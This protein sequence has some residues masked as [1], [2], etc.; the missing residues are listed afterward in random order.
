MI[1]VIT[2]DIINSRKSLHGGNWIK[3]LETVL[4]QY[5]NRFDRWDI[6]R[7]DSFQLEL[8]CPQYALLAAIHIK[9]KVKTVKGL[10]VRMAIGLGEKT[11]E[12]NRISESNGPAFIYSGELFE[13]LKSMKRNAAIKSPWPALDAEL[14]LML[15][16]ASIAMDRWSPSSA[17]I[18]L[19]SLLHQSL[20]QQ[21]LGEKI[22]IR[23]S[24]VSERQSRAYY[25]EIM[26]LERYYR[27][28]FSQ[29][30]HSS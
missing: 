16:L 28:R 11:Y 22:G 30:N 5:G 23:Q 4:S 6:F 18:V 15:G 8:I 3:P 27:T 14:N 10:D 12:A 25:S 20:S 7:G 17:E 1:A 21:E 19:M 2:G 29:Q 26:E 24:S 9:A 13:S